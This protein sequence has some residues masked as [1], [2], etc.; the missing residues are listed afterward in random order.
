MIPAFFM[1]IDTIPLKANGKFDRKALPKPDASD[2]KTEYVAPT[3]ETEEKL[4]NAMA[5][6]LKADKIGIHDD[7]IHNQN[8]FSEKPGQADR[9]PRLRFF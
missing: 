6:V 7:I 5:T 2:F 3:N 1:K 4:C 8:L 9:R